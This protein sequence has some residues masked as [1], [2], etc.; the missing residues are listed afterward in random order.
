MSPISPHLVPSRPH[1]ARSRPISHPSSSQAD[2]LRGGSVA[3]AAPRGRG[4]RAHPPR[5]RHGHATRGGAT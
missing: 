5:A 4:S 2:A 1:L 3:A